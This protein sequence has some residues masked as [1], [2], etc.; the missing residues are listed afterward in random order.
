MADASKRTPLFSTRANHPG[1]QDTLDD[2]VMSLGERIDALQDAEIASD[3]PRMGVLAGELRGAAA[4]HGYEPLADCA[5]GV[6]TACASGDAEVAH[7]GLLELTE[8]AQRVRLGHR[9]AV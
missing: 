1:V 6:R 2:F 3:L 5:A 9:G 4:D 8:I 7:K